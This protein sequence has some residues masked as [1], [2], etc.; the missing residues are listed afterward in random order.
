MAKFLLEKQQE[1]DILNYVIEEE[2]YKSQE[3]FNVFDQMAQGISK[4]E[5]EGKL[6]ED[7]NNLLD[8]KRKQIEGEQVTQ[9]VD[10][11]MDPNLINEQLKNSFK[12]PEQIKF[13]GSPRAAKDA[14]I[15]EFTK[16]LGSN[17]Y[18]DELQVNKPV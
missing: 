10:F 2:A 4:D 14:S 9:K 17:Y 6:K 3:N 5:I 8:T 18:D 11:H 15:K 12:P 13:V 7:F 16:K 1:N